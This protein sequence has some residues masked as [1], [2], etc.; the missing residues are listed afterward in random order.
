MSMHRFFI[1]PSCFEDQQVRLTGDQAHQICHVLRLQVDQR[2][3]VLDGRGD[4]YEVC[5]REV[6]AKQVVG[7]RVARRHAQGEP[8]TSVM[9]LQSLLKR[10][11][12]EW[13]LQKATEVGVSMIVPVITA[14]SLIRDNGPF[15]PARLARWQRILTEAAEQAHRGRIPTLGEPVTLA[16][17]LR[18]AGQA[19]RSLM[20]CPQIESRSLC[21]CLED[22]PRAA[23]LAVFIGPEGG[24]AP[25]EIDQARQAGTLPI[26]LGPRILRTET[27]AIVAVSLLL[28][29]RGEFGC[30][31]PTLE[32]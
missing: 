32:P 4:E 10:D 18:L 26:N 13:V 16:E 8:V 2:I 28:Y 1:A 17:G 14:R 9:L 19:D 21:A 29:E 5:L 23:S 31:N 12:F 27:A 30:P 15:K 25:E 11:K 24:F 7:D 3:V 6:G 22:V 20:A